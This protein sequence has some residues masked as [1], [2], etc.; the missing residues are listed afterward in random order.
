MGSKKPKPVKPE[1]GIRCPKCHCRYCPV[2]ETR[3]V[4]RGIMRVR[5]CNHCKTRIRSYERTP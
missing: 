4:A 5:I 1:V 3:P 2:W